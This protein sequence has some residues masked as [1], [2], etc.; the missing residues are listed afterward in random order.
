MRTSYF[1]FN[2]CSFQFISSTELHWG[3]T[4]K[5]TQV[6]ANLRDSCKYL[7]VTTS[8]AS[9]CKYLQVSAN[10]ASPAS[11]CKSLQILQVPEIRCKYIRYLQVVPP[12][13]INLLCRSVPTDNSLEFLIIIIYKQLLFNEVFYSFF[14]KTN[15]N[16]LFYWS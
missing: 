11:T 3:I 4:K 14:S 9:L 12:W 5:W 1:V 10:L 13:F 2:N 16:L 8:P 7:Q 6:L 15:F